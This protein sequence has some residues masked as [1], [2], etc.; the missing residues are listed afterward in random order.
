MSCDEEAV[1]VDVPPDVVPWKYIVPPLPPEAVIVWLPQNV[2][3]PET[4]TVPGSGL[5]LNIEVLPVETTELHVVDVTAIDAIVTVV[6]PDVP[7]LPDG[8]ENVPLPLVSVSDAVRPV[9]EFTPLR[10]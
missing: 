10:L 9:A 7:R 4:V 8:I 6:E 3:P 5:T 1:A 2:P